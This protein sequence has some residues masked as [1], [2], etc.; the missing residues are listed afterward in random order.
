MDMLHTLD[1]AESLLD[2]LDGRQ[3]AIKPLGSG[4]LVAVYVRPNKT[5]GGILL[6]DKSQDEDKFQGKV[7][8]VLKLGPIAFV[9][10]DTH[11][12]GEDIP[13]P[14]DWVVYNV[15]E[16]FAFNM[17]DVRCRIVEDVA[18]RAITSRPDMV[19]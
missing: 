2:E 18:V 13:Q 8:L 1:P 5:K 14:G 9:D 11:R 12:F 16:T 7:G 17:G 10:D 6:T 15:G 4:V 3:D 19:Y